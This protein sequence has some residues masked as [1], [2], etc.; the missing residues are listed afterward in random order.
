M[1]EKAWIDV[2]SPRFFYF[3]LIPYIGVVELGAKPAMPPT[4]PHPV[5]FIGNWKNFM[6]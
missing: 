1:T 2:K 3:P 6:F 5:S 4:H